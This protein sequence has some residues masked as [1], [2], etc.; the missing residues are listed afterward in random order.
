[1]MDLVVPQSEFDCATLLSRLRW[2]D[3]FRC[4]CGC[5]RFGRILTRP[6]VWRCNACR[7]QRSV[8]AG[9][10]LHRSH[11]TIRAWM[12]AAS[13]MCEP[14]G[15]SAAALA[16]RQQ[17][18]YETA[19][20]LAH[21]LRA[22]VPP[23]L[24]PPPAP[25]HVGVTRLTMRDEP[26]TRPIV[27]FVGKHERSLSMLP[28]EAPTLLKWRIAAERG[29]GDTWEPGNAL[30][31]RLG[32]VHHGVSNR[33]L[34]SYVGEFRHQWLRGGDAALELALRAA[35]RE[36]IPWKALP[37]PRWRRPFVGEPRQGFEVLP[38]QVSRA[39]ADPSRLPPAR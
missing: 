2:P 14:G 24:E 38:S 10:A 17:R 37:P 18:R 5:A 34:G 8:T 20:R 6:R 11:L 9:T 3:G 27:V 1:V 29:R 21:K 13:G 32:S 39:P 25:F 36:W 30:W 28:V 19:W 15:L 16:E 35:R 31:R 26:H 4:P 7:R 12:L 33:W 22:G 23:P